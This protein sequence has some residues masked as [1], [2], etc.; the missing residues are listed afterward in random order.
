[1]CG[2]KVNPALKGL[3]N[4]TAIFSKNKKEKGK[5]NQGSLNF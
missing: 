4:V 3:K 2:W 5:N 1:M